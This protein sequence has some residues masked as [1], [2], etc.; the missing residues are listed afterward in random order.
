MAL[1]LKMGRPRSHAVPTEP[2]GARHLATLQPQLFIAQ[3][4][5]PLLKFAWEGQRS[6]PLEQTNDTLEI[7]PIIVASYTY[8]L[9]LM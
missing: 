9:D 1:V 6:L 7:V 4:V 5:S 8:M 2:P 3:R